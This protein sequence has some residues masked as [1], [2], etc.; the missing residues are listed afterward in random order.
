MISK[1]Y[2]LERVKNLEELTDILYIKTKG[3]D[4]KIESLETKNKMLESFLGIEMKKGS[5]EILKTE[6]KYIKSVKKTKR[7][8]K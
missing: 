5:I 8:T 6:P 4:S 3:L 7:N 2:L 1:K